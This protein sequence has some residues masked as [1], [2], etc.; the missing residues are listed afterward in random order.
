MYHPPRQKTNPAKRKE[1]ESST[2]NDITMKLQIMTRKAM[3]SEEASWSNAVETGEDAARALLSLSSEGNGNRSSPQSSSIPPATG[4]T[5]ID[6]ADSLSSRRKNGPPEGIISV[7]LPTAYNH[8]PIPVA[9]SLS[10]PA[11]LKPLNVVDYRD[12]IAVANPPTAIEIPITAFPRFLPPPPVARQS[13]PV[14][15]VLG[16]PPTA[17]F[18]AIAT[19]RVVGKVHKR[20]LPPAKHRMEYKCYKMSREAARRYIAELAHQTASSDNCPGVSLSPLPVSSLSSVPTVL[21][22]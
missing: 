15:P 5:T 13:L 20:N 8:Q 18:P 1:P 4:T 19:S 6:K 17:P 11:I 3:N 16:H 2:I 21:W 9:S 12:P 22:S 7:A 14:W 10:S